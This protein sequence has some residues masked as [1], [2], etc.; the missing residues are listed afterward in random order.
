LGNRWAEIAKYLPGRSDN[1]IKNHWNS[2]M[3]K[4]LDD[5][6]SSTP[7]TGNKEPKYRQVKHNRNKTTSSSSSSTTTTPLSNLSTNDSQFY[8]QQQHQYYNPGSID[9]NNYYNHNNYMWSDGSIDKE[10]QL[11]QTSTP[12]LLMNENS[13]NNFLSIFDNDDLN[14]IIKSID[15]ESVGMS[16]IDEEQLFNNIISTPRKLYKQTNIAS[17]RTPTP[18]KKA[19]AKIILK[20]EQLERIRQSTKNL[21]T[22]LQSPITN[23]FLTTNYCENNVDSG[24]ISFTNN[25]NNNNN[26]NQTSF[27]N[28]SPDNFINNNSL[29]PI[30]INNNKSDDMVENSSNIKVFLF[31]Y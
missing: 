8:N 24:F 27:Y 31:K 9:N 18:L 10:N 15:L 25:N 5:S 12:L 22:Q 16:Q 11:K 14:S 26:N 19:M 6:N 29:K 20:E 23:D 7:K 3:K 4:K 30:T 21:Q 28:E 17:I 2:T 1:A 13:N